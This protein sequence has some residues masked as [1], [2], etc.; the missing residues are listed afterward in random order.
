MAKAY[1]RRSKN[2]NMNEKNKNTLL[3]KKFSNALDITSSKYE[4]SFKIRALI[5]AIPWAG[6]SLDTMLS[7]EGIRIKKRMCIRFDK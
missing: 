5:Q 3:P 1:V 6:S 7:A 4:E 2:K